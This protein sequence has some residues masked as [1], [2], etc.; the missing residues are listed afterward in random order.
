MEGPPVMP[1]Q[2][3]LQILDRLDAS[4]L[5]VWVDGGWGV[6]ALLGRQTRPHKDLDLVVEL[7]RADEIFGVLEDLEFRVSR[8]DR[9]V[10]VEMHDPIGHKVG[11][12]TVSFD[13][14][15]NGIQVQPSGEEFVYSS[16]GLE[17][18]GLI[19]G[20]EVKCLSPELQ[21]RCHQ[22]YNPTPTTVMTL[23]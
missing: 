8:D 4:N 16:E 3:A 17:A 22:G 12:H 19:Q 13:A 21:L 2:L 11:L 20:R 18:R 14:D 6:D 9:P 15:G 23:L 10:R 5:S 7:D 1:A